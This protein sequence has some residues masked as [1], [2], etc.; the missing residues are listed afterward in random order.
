MSLQSD[1]FSEWF[2]KSTTKHPDG[3]PISFYHGTSSDVSEFSHSKI[4][5]GN[6]WGRGFYFT[7]SSKIA[8]DYAMGTTTGAHSRIAPAGDAAPNVVPVHLK[9]EKP[10]LMDAPLDVGLVRRTERKLGYSLKNHVW[11]GMRNRDLHQQ[12]HHDH[13][14]GGIDSVNEMLRGFGY[15]GIRESSPESIH[16]VFDPTRIKSAIGNSGNY[17]P[18]SPKLIESLDAFLSEAKTGDYASVKAEIAQ[19]ILDAVEEAKFSVDP[20]AKDKL[21]CTLCYSI[22]TAA[23]HKKIQA[24]LDSLTMPI[25]GSVTHLT[26]FDA[27]PK[28]GE[29]AKDECTIVMEVDCKELDK[30]HSTLKK[31]GM[32]HS[33][34]E[35][36]PHVSLVYDVPIKE[37][38][39][40]MK[41]IED[42]IKNTMVKFNHPTIEKLNP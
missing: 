38:T 34:D 24:Y 10:F 37:A 7:P 29:R 2:G 20:I 16:M 12:L 41:E 3:T 36:R 25:S 21:H 8:S 35:F 23:D 5:G 22:G 6:Q 30:I 11:H 26:K 31:M 15:D 17:S 33:Y 42:K 32:K 39:S 9:M 1:S 13:L 28:D 40:K 27:L 4:G 19:K 18:K 14:S